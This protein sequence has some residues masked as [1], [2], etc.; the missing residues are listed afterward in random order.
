MISG[1]Y[2]E[3]T[4]G[5]VEPMHAPPPGPDIAAAAV[6][7]ADQPPAPVEDRATAAAPAVADPAEKPAQMPE[8]EPTV[9]VPASAG[10]EVVKDGEVKS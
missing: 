1:W 6:K 9:P 3:K 8:Q 4:P 7:S 5:V 10:K 2:K